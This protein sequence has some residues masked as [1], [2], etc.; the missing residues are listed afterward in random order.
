ML[1][2]IVLNHLI[3]QTH[4]LFTCTESRANTNVYCQLLNGSK[5][6][7]LLMD[8]DT[9]CHQVK[10]KWPNGEKKAA[11]SNARCS[12]SHVMQNFREYYNLKCADA[13]ECMRQSKAVL[14]NN[15]MQ[16]LNIE[17]DKI[18]PKCYRNQVQM[19]YP[20]TKQ[21]MVNSSTECT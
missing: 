19:V 2:R 8:H 6:V 10:M 17:I 7:L 18:T 4:Q 15:T 3:D 21:E 14:E 16:A 13:C 12:H 1:I 11:I 20:T 9:I 5:F